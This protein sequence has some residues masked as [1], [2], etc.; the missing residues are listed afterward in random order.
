MKALR[1]GLLTI[2]Y[3]TLPPLIAFLTWKL[4]NASL[5]VVSILTYCLLILAVIVLRIAET[6]HK[7][8]EVSLSNRQIQESAIGAAAYFVGMGYVVSGGFEATFGSEGQSILLVG[9]VLVLLFSVITLA[10]SLFPNDRS[11]RMNFFFSRVFLLILFPIVASILIAS[12]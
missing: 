10:D 6:N 2:F 4:F 11:G 7:L 5:A 12:A 3:S 1:D 9:N 8:P